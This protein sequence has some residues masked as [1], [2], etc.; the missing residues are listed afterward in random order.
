MTTETLHARWWG[1]GWNILSKLKCGAFKTHLLLRRIEVRGLRLGGTHA[2]RVDLV[3][4][5]DQHDFA[6]PSQDSFWT[7]PFSGRD[8]LVSNALLPLL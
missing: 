7:V 1:N 6:A 5:A 8:L 4:G 2:K 3:G